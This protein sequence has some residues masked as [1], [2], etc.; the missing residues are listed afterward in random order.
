MS[1]LS[2]SLSGLSSLL[3]PLL[4]VLMLTVSCSQIPQFLTGGGPNVAANVQAGK[5]NSQTIGTTNNIAPTVS[6]R[7]NSRV[8]TIDQRNTTTRVSSDAVETIVVNELPIW[9]VLLFGLLCGFVIPS[10]REIAR[11]VLSLFRRSS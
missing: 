4:L 1:R 10:P 2:K 11:S 7:P 3:L 6:V 5:T 9:L 8:D